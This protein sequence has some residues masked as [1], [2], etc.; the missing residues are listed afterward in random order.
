MKLIRYERPEV[1]MPLS[2]LDSWARD[3][4]MGMGSL[5][6]RIFDG[7]WDGA[8]AGQR[9]AADLFEDSEAF[10]LRLEVPG[11]KKKDI[12]VE[13]DNAVIT[14]SYERR[15]K[16]KNNGE[17]SESFSRSISVPDGV[18]TDN[19]HAKLEDGVLTV[20]LPKAESRKPRSIKVG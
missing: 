15:A 9:L 17:E 1:R 5:W 4:F 12:R 16:S 2:R 20:T 19:V 8:L 6:P 18:L 3:P 10:Y 7:E 13:L 11:V 14:V